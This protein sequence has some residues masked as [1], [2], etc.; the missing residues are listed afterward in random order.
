[1]TLHYLDA[2]ALAKLYISEPG[3]ELM[4]RLA[5]PAAGHRFAILALTEVEFRSAVRRRERAGDFSGG[6]AEIALEALAADLGTAALQRRP[7]DDAALGLAAL[8][9]DRHPLKANDAL[10]LAGC[11]ILRMVSEVAP[12]FVCSDVRL[13]RAAQGEGLAV[14][15]PA[16]GG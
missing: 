2:S 12:V 9:V 7:V 5:D 10:Q 4:R 6:V 3:T 11:L 8:V 14:L 16:P 13:L 15:N 1:M